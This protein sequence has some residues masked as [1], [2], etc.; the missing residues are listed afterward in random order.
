MRRDTERPPANDAEKVAKGL[1][2]VSLIW[3]A[4]K[5]IK[6]KITPVLIIPENGGPKI[7]SEYLADERDRLVAAN[8]GMSQEKLAPVGVEH[9]ESEIGAGVPQEGS[10]YAE[11][12]NS[13]QHNQRMMNLNM[14][15]KS[16]KLRQ[17]AK[18]ALKTP[19]GY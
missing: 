7:M 14:S 3:E 1:S 15:Q 10:L 17:P 9:T 18:L 5:R 13:Y 16:T 19:L 2:M 12:I 4:M 6:R 11:I 8:T